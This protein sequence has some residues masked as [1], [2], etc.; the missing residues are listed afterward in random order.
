M[1]LDRSDMRKILDVLYEKFPYTVDPDNL[2]V[3]TNG[4]AG[5]GTYLHYLEGHGLVEFKKLHAAH[6]TMN[7]NITQVRI[8]SKGIDFIMDDGGLSA[9][10]G[11]VTVKL[12][13]DTIR[14]LLL[15]GLEDN[16]AP[17]SEK[18]PLR[19]AIRKAPA[20]A[21]NKVIESLVGVALSRTPDALI[22]LQNAL[23]ASQ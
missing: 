14:A 21:F 23:H 4:E 5:V 15:K 13:E 8:T 18:A 10:F 3:E 12:H 1:R 17:E 6:G 16:P 2:T 22:V 7:F 11:V 19:E 9:I 20:T